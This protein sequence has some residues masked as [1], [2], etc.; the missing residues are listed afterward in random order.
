MKFIIPCPLLQLHVDLC[1]HHLGFSLETGGAAKN[2]R[3]YPSI[4]NHL[5]EFLKQGDKVNK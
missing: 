3:C 5:Y 1:Q 2:S 4:F